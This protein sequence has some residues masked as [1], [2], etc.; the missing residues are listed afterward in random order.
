MQAAP[1]RAGK[2]FLLAGLYTA[3]GEVAPADD[4]WKAFQ[5]DFEAWRKAGGAVQNPC[6]AHRYADCTHW[7]ESRKPISGPELLL[8]GKT[9]FTLQQYNHAAETL[10]R[11]LAVNKG[12]V[13]ASYWL[14]R[15][16]QALGA[17]CYDRLE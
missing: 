15:S 10:A 17:E 5:A 8:L 6:R 11:L 2:N 13:E 14:A 3:A 12:N 7:L 16:Y 1:P 9:Q 4:R